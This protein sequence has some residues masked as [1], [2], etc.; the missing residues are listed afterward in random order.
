M[1]KHPHLHL[2]DKSKRWKY[3][4]LGTFPPNTDIRHPDKVYIDYFY[5]NSGTLWKII[6][7]LY[8]DQGYDFF[9]GTKQQNGQSIIKW[10]QD[11]CVALCDTILACDRKHPHSTN[12]SDLISIQYNFGLKE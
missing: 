5:G 12:D 11:Y 8:K 2:F 10:Q 7:D 3:L 9:G 1:E 4:I 6:H